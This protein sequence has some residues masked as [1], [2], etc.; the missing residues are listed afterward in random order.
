MSLPL[1]PH[2]N[3]NVQIARA[4]SPAQTSHASKTGKEVASPSSPST[5]SS[6]LVSSRLHLKD[7]C[8]HV[9]NKIQPQGSN[10]PRLLQK[11][12]RETTVKKGKLSH[13]V[14]NL[15]FK[16]NFI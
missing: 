9:I 16:L 15:V 13:K 7:D 2:V 8:S 10:Q 5:N 12:I 4:I 11:S 6:K 14:A 3:S 1:P